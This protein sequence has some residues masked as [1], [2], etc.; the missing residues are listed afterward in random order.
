MFRG[1]SRAIMMD[2]SRCRC[3]IDACA[4]H[5]RK[6]L[7][8]AGSGVPHPRVLATCGCGA[9]KELRDCDSSKN[10]CQRIQAPIDPIPLLFKRREA[11]ENSSQW[12]HLD[13]SVPSHLDISTNASTAY[14]PQP[15]PNQQPRL[16]LHDTCSPLTILPNKSSPLSYAMHQL[17]RAPS[18][19]DRSLNT[20]RTNSSHKPS[21]SCSQNDLPV[22]ESAQ[23]EQ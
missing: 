22:H 10:F 7:R 23:R 11:A 16:S 5:M 8:A 1:P 20:S 6:R 14:L 21:P 3:C 17:T 19:P 13:C 15:R 9:C 18:S 4:R 2:A 12:L